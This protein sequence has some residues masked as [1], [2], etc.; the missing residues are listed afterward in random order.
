MDEAL[1]DRFRP[2]TCTIKYID[3]PSLS[4]KV[5]LPFFLLKVHIIHKDG[6]YEL[7]RLG[8]LT[9]EGNSDCVCQVVV[10]HDTWYCVELEEGAPYSLFS[11]VLM[12]GMFLY[13]I[14]LRKKRHFGMCEQ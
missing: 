2:R 11:A 6:S 14:I 1:T 3:R 10:P 5:N 12:P 7:F 13:M 8:D 4:L 9:K